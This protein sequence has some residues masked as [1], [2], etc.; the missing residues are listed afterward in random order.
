MNA[1][2]QIKPTVVTSHLNA[3]RRRHQALDGRVD[4]ENRRLNP[5]STLLQRLKRERLRLRDELARYE[6]L[7][8]RRH[9]RTARA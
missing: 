6:A 4:A 7:M 2:T 8:Q 9:D 1:I 5:D 3:L